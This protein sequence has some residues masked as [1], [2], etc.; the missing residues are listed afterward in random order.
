[1][2]AT[3][4][5]SLGLD[6]G[7]STTQLVLSRLTL[8]NAASPFAVPKIIIS[9][10]EII[11]RSA[12][13]FTPL[14][15]DTLIDAGGIRAI[16]AAEYEKAGIAPGDIET[17]AVIITG[18]TARK[19]NAQE[20]LTAL[21]GF[22]GDCVVATA[23]PVLESVLAAKGAGIDRRSKEERRQILNCDVGGGTS[24]LALFENGVLQKTDC[25]NIGGRLVQIDPKTRKIT[26]ISKNIDVPAAALDGLQVGVEV[27]EDSLA[28][29]IDAMV[30]ALLKAAAGC[31]FVSFSGGVADCIWHREPDFLRYG[32]LGPLL[33]GA[34]LRRFPAAGFTLLQGAETIRATVVG[35]GSHSA[36]LSGSTIFYR[37]ITFP[38]KNLPV[39]KMTPEEETGDLAGAITEKLKLFASDEATATVIALTGTPSPA[40][41]QVVRLA[42]HLAKALKPL[43]GA[44]LPIVVMVEQDMAKTLGQALFPLIRGG[45]LLVLDGVSAET[46]DYIDLQ[47]P[48]YNGTVLP[49]VVKTLAFE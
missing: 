13:H 1:M 40:Y 16:V 41:S 8:E 30:E 43:A 10:K 19:E 28:L 23:G 49:V 7:T 48:A 6:L 39:L 37:N 46:G 22:A 27:T 45:K 44:D 12:I 26:K 34:I 36:E 2:S 21:A 3:T 42:D 47:A 17:G 35:A 31:K 18:E 25:L 4:L 15:S 24:N 33:G 5:L 9:K 11:Y 29:L 38:L 32:D 20:V 14:L